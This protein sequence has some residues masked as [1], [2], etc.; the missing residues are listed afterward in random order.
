M[1]SRQPAFNVPW[2]VIVLIAL[3]CAVHWWLWSQEPSAV[4]WWLLALALIPA[5][6]EGLAVLLPGGSTAA[7]TSLV[8]H[9]GVHAD[10][11]HL[12]MNTTALLAFGGAVA[13][14]VGTLRFLV[15]TLLCGLAGAALFLALNWGGRVPMIGASGA[16]SG[17]VAGAFRFFLPTLEG[18]GLEGFHRDPRSTP[19]L[20]LAETLRNRRSQIA[21]CVWLVINFMMGLGGPAITG[22]PGIAWEAHLGGFIAGLVLMSPFD[23]PARPYDLEAGPEGTA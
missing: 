14:R 4:R 17:L 23:G 16:V 5:R 18:G 7:W 2:I 6:F 8:T 20:S 9:M 12:V 19:L 15:F 1:D 21:I 11:T 3:L 10:L 13:K 22:G